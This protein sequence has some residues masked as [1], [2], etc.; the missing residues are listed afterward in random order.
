MF[1]FL[2]LQQR[3]FTPYHHTG[4]PGKKNHFHPVDKNGDEVKNGRNGGVHFQYGKK[5]GK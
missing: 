3:G 5:I 2:G 4:A 1:E